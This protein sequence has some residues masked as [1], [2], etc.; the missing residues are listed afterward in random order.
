MVL[1]SVV[2]LPDDSWLDAEDRLDNVDDDNANGDDD[3]LD[4]MVFIIIFSFFSKGVTKTLFVL[5]CS[6]LQSKKENRFLKGK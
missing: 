2:L 5:L 4:E 1:V 6:Q 3:D